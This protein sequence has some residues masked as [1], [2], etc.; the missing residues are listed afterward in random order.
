M[1]GKPRSRKG[2]YSP[3]S[4]KK[5]RRVDRPVVPAGQSAVTPADEAVPSPAPQLSSPLKS[6]PAPVAKPVTVANPYIGRELRTIAILAVVMLII[7]LV[8]AK[9]LS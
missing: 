7:L 8:L 1:P 5:K 4:K 3:Q 6:A 9:V 2:G